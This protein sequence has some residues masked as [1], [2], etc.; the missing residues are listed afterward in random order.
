MKRLPF[1]FHT[2]QYS[3]EYGDLDIYAT[4]YCTPDFP[5]TMYRNNGDPGDP[6]ESGETVWETV[7]IF[8]AANILRF[9]LSRKANEFEPDWDALKEKAREDAEGRQDVRDNRED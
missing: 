2:V 6:P 9:A 1:D 4:G 8:D 7:E 5:G 3:E